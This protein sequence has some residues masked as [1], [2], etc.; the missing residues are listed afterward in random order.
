[1]KKLVIFDLDGTLL[2]SIADLA[3][4]TNHALATLGFPTHQTASYPFMVGNGINVLF[5]R[6][7]P[8]GEKTEENIRLVRQLFVPHYDAHNADASTPYPGT[9]ELLQTMQAKGMQLAVASNKY[10]A[11]TEKLVAHYFPNIAF[12]AVLGQR[13]G[14]NVKPDPVIVFDILRM[15]D[16]AK[17]K[18][19]Y[20]GDSGVDMQT[21]IRAG[22]I[23]CGVT[24]GFRPRA[25]LEAHNPDFIV[26]MAEE[27]LT[28]AL[29]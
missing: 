10:Q 24:W 13:E 2:N 25:E 22:V 29:Q 3:A 18:T 15:A 21:A 11:A 12:T 17:E 16:V 9:I 14:V 4:S 19:L 26:D 23:S 1:M 5:E 20:V 28:I 6:A 7:L 8:E 27:I